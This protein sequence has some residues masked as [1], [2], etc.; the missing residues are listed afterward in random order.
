MRGLDFLRI[1]FLRN[2]A[3][4]ARLARLAPSGASALADALASVY[5]DR[6]DKV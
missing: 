6:K 2:E 3:R 4:R 1:G 5:D